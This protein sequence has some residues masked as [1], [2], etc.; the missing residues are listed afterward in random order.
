MK[1]L[2]NIDNEDNYLPH[3]ETFSGRLKLAHFVGV[4]ML[5]YMIHYFIQCNI[6]GDSYSDPDIFIAENVFSKHF[7]Q[8]LCCLT[9]DRGMQCPQSH[10]LDFM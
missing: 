2:V 5:I 8:V 4:C 6:Q 9:P 3:N 10:Q 1:E 7:L